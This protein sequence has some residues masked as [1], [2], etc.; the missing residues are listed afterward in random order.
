M[1]FSSSFKHLI[2]YSDIISFEGVT[3]GVQKTIG[4]LILK[5]KYNNLI[6]NH[7]FHVINNNTWIPSFG[8]LG[9]DFLD[10]RCKCD[11][12]N[13][14]IEF[15]VDEE[16]IILPILSG[17][18]HNEIYIPP[19]TEIVRRVH[20]ENEEDLVILGGEVKEGIFVA[21][22]IINKQSPFIQVVNTNENPKIL[23]INTIKF[24]KLSK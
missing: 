16:S 9:R 6:V 14:N 10:G 23:N 11:F 20:I 15:I 17:P 8:L 3:P 13:Y 24:T 19:N 1:K 22:S 21:G 2:N 7:K 12:I 5:L 18:N 4:S